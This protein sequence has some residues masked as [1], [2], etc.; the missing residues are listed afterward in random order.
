V[1][2]RLHRGRTNLRTLLVDIAAARGY[3]A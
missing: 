3:A 2:S 1:M